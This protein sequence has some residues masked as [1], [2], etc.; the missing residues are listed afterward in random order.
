[1]PPNY[2]RTCQIHRLRGSWTRICMDRWSH[3]KID[4]LQSAAED[5]GTSK[6]RTFPQSAALIGG[7]DEQDSVASGNYSSRLTTLP[8]ARA[9][10]EFCNFFFREVLRSMIRNRNG[11][12]SRGKYLLACLKP[13]LEIWR[14]HTG[15]DFGS[16]RI[17]RTSKPPALT[18]T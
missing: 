12:C 3:V 16:C 10:L 2:D 15:S 11:T 13:V 8:Q 5:L 1:M 18:H 6:S 17:L 14:E 9:N 7:G 4:S